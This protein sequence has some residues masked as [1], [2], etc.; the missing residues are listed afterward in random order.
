MFSLFR[1]YLPLE[2]GVVI[3]LQ[4]LECPSP[5]DALCKDCMVEIGPVVLQKKMKLLN[6]YDTSDAVLLK[7]APFSYR[8]ESLT[9]IARRSSSNDP[10]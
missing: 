10:A 2:K 9:G 5:K 8:P 6:V 1:Y 4:K 7:P 3:I